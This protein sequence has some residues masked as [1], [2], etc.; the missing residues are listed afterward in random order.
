M[1]TK[2]LL[3]KQD[4]S[5]NDLRKGRA[6]AQKEYSASTCWQAVAKKL[7]DLAK[8]YAQAWKD[9]AHLL[10]TLSERRPIGFRAGGERLFDGDAIRGACVAAHPA[11]SDRLEDEKAVCGTR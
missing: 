6:K 11:L 9:T 3:F 4:G 1:Q 10:A 2:Q 8:T 5:S 7:K